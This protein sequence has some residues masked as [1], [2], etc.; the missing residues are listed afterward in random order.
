MKY[1]LLD[2]GT[3]K[4]TFDNGKANALSL[5]L[6]QAIMQGLEQ[7][8][9]E[10]NSVLLCGHPGMFMA[11]FDLKVLAQGEK[12]AQ[13]MLDSGMHLVEKLY[14]HPQPV[15]TVCEGHAVGMGVFLMLAADY[16]IAVSGDFKMRLPETAI[17]MPF[18]ALLREVAITHITPTHHGRAIVQSRPYNPEQA[19]EIGMVDEVVAPDQAHQ[20]AMLRIGEMTELPAEQYAANKLFIRA[21]QIDKI[22]AD[23]H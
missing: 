12:A 1:Q 3:A 8:Q 22:R 23:L 18:N 4:I 19:A 21:A 17:G 9:Q 11:G 16:R 6:S 15:V 10:A 14:S 5:E 2:N 7:A 13:A 20:Q